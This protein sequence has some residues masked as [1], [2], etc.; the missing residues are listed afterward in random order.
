MIVE[1]KTPIPEYIQKVLKDNEEILQK[2]N[3]LL[4]TVKQTTSPD[5]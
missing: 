2:M 1:I 3:E 5:D 4:E